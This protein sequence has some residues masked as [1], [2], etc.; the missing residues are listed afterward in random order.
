MPDRL[1]GKICRHLTCPE[2][3]ITAQLQ[4]RETIGLVAIRETLAED[5]GTIIAIPQPAEDQLKRIHK[6]LQVL[7]FETRS[8]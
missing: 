3:E 5:A 7:L 6:I 8:S 4:G 1:I 2:V